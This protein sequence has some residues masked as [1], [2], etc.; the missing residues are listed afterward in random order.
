MNA[1]VSD[2][3]AYPSVL[4]AEDPVV[5]RLTSTQCTTRS[6]SSQSEPCPNMYHQSMRQVSLI[7]PTLTSLATMHEGVVII[8]KYILIHVHAISHI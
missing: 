4:L 8:G 6:R 7:I 5:G 1:A 3:E 2:D